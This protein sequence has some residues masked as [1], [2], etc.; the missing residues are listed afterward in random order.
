M[1]ETI[2]YWGKPELQIEE[3]ANDSD[4][5]ITVPAGQIWRV[6][7]IHVELATTATVGNRQIAI[8]GRDASDDI[9]F[10]ESA[11]AVQAA[12]LTYT[13]TCQPGAVREAAFVNG[14][15]NLPIPPD[16]ILPAGY[17][18]HIFDSAAVAAAADD[19]VVQ[20]MV[21]KRPYT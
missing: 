14:Q 5:P 21:E 17:D 8:E 2:A 1:A 19:M 7:W 6:L 20:M 4:K 13:Y 3:T 12:S 9:I 18:V 16:F 11:G 15:I 10:S